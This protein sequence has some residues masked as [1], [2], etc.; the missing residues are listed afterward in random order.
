MIAEE[1]LTAVNL[2]VDN[3]TSTVNKLALLLKVGQTRDD[4]RKILEPIKSGSALEVRQNEG[5]FVRTVCG[6]QGQNNVVQQVRLTC[7]RHSLRTSVWTR[8]SA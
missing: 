1:L 2:T 5:D 7:S 4:V 6:A 3:V 8:P